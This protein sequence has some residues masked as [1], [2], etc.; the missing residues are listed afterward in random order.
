MYAIRSYYA[1]SAYTKLANE[2]H[3]EGRDRPEQQC[4][5]V[6][7]LGAESV[8]NQSANQHLSGSADIE[9]AGSESERRITS[10]NVCYTKLLRIGVRPRPGSEDDCRAG[11][12]NPQ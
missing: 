7:L 5:A 3:N 9:Q 10:Y 1:R 4:R 2:A 12:Q 8:Q 6:N 11:S